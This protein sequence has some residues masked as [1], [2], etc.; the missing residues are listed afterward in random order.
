MEDVMTVTPHILRSPLGT[1]FEA[2]GTVEM[3]GVS[4]LIVVMSLEQA[5]RIID[6]TVAGN[7]IVGRFGGM[8]PHPVT[9]EEIE[10]V[11]TRHGIYTVGL[12]GHDG[13]SMDV[14]PMEFVSYILKDAEPLE[15]VS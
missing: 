3:G 4:S 12:Y 7:A 10:A 9:V 2:V 8:E 5:Q 11:C 14:I 1:D 13:D 15:G 6:A